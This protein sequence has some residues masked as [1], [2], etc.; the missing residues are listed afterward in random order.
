MLGVFVDWYPNPR[1]WFHTGARLGV[2][3]YGAEDSAHREYTSLAP[4]ASAVLGSSSWI[5]PEAS[6][7][8][9]IVASITGRGE[10]TDQYQN[11]TGYR[12]MGASLVFDFALLYH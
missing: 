7:D 12:L 11:D 4:V 2:G 5:G 8:I 9:S 3:G 10:G 6:T 1:G